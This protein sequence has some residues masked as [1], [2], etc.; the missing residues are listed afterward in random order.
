M[1]DLHRVVTNSLVLPVQSYGLKAICKHPGL[2]NFQWSDEGSGSQWSIVQFQQ[3][4]NETDGP[5]RD[6]L[7]AQICAYNR[8]DVL[9][10]RRLEQWLR[11]HFPA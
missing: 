2:V 1:F 7:K 6:A 9:A 10:T 8:D 5:A 11:Q 3:F 4:L